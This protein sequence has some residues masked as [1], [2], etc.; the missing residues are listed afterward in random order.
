MTAEQKAIL[1]GW[2]RFLN[3]LYPATPPAHVE[4]RSA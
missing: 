4:R 3:A 1:D 2:N